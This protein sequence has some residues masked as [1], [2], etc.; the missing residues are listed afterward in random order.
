MTGSNAHDR[1]AMPDTMADFTDDAPV[2]D[3]RA[4]PD[5]PARENNPGAV[6]VHAAAPSLDGGRTEIAFVDTSVADY[7]T[8]AAD[9]RPGVEVVEIS[10]QDGLQQI[11]AYLAGRSDIAAV[12]IFSHGSAG[13]LAFGGEDVEADT[14]GTYQATLA[15][16]GQ[17]LAPGGDLLLYGCD[18]AAGS[19][20]QAL[21]SQIAAYSH[22]N[23]AA[24]TNP[25]GAASAGGDWD[26]EFHV[27]TID[28]A[29]AI[30]ATSG[31]NYRSVLS[32]YA[33]T[34]RSG[35]ST[36]SAGEPITTTYQ[37]LTIK[38]S[39]SGPGE[40]T[41]LV[42]TPDYG[43]IGTTY[44]ATTSQRLDF[45][46][47]N[48]SLFSVT[49]LYVDDP[50][51]SPTSVTIQGYNA[52]GTQTA[53]VTVQIPSQGGPILVNLSGMSGFA[54]IADLA[55]SAPDAVSVENLTLTTAPTV[56]AINRHAGSATPTNASSVIFDVTF[57]TAV[58]GVSAGNFTVTT[59]GVTVG[60]IG[61]VSGSGTA[62]TVTV[63]GVAGDGTLGLNLSSI[64]GITDTAG[65][66][67]G[68]T[69]TGDQSYT[70]DH[71]AP[72][73]GNLDGDSVLFVA[74]AAA[75]LVDN[76]S[77]ATVTEIN[78]ASGAILTAT[79]A[80]V[81]SSQD[82]LG[83]ATVSGGITTT[84]STTKTVLD[85][86]T[87][88]GTIAAATNGTGGQPLTVTLNTGDTI[89][90]VADLIRA[91]TYNDT[92]SAPTTTARSVQVTLTDAAGNISS[93]S[94]VA[95]QLDQ[96]PVVSAGHTTT[97]VRAQ[98]PAPFDTTLGI[99]DPDGNWTG[100]SVKFAVTT[101]FAANDMLSIPTTSQS[102]IW[103][104]G[105][106]LMD[107]ATQIGTGATSAVTGSATLT[108]TLNAAA[109]NVTVGALGQAVSIAIAAGAALTTRTVKIIATDSN[110]VAVTANDT[111][112]VHAQPTATGGTSHAVNDNA[113]TTPLTGISFSDGTTEGLTVRVS[114]AGATGSFG[115]PAGWSSSTTSGTTT[116]VQDFS[117]STPTSTAAAALAALIF[118]PIAHAGNVGSTQAIPFT[119]TATGDSIGAA[120]T[121]ISPSATVTYVNTTPSLAIGGTASTFFLG[122]SPVIMDSGATVTDPDNGGLGNW[123]GGQLN[124]TGLSV[125]DPVLPMLS[126]ANTGGISVSGTAISY[127]GINIGVSQSSQPSSAISVS[128]D[129]AATDAAVQALFRAITYSIN[130]PIFDGNH[131]VSVTARDGSAASFSTT[132]IVVVLNGTSV[133]SINRAA[134]MSSGPTDASTLSFTVTF[135]A[136]VTGVSVS[137]FTV[138][139][140]GSATGSL[141]GVS[142]SGTSWTVTVAGVAGDGTLGLN[143]SNTSGIQDAQGNPLLATYNS[144]QTF[145]LDHT[146][147][148]VNG[149]NGNAD[150]FV[151]GNSAIVLQPFLDTIVTE[152][153]PGG[154]TLTVQ[155]ANGLP[156][157][158][159]GLLTGGLAGGPIAVSNGT[160]TDDGTTIGT[161]AAGSNGV[162][163][164]L[165]VSL[166]S[167]DTAA[168]VSALVSILSYSDTSA[169][170]IVATRTIDLT[171]S[172]GAGNISAVS[173]ATVAIDHPPV[174]TA[175]HSTNTDR[176]A[177]LPIDPALQVSDADANWSGGRLVVQLSQNAVSTDTLSLPSISSSGIWLNGTALMAGS[178]Q[179]GTASAASVQGSTS[180]TFSLDANAT[181]AAVTALAQTVRFTAAATATLN[182][183][184]ITILAFDGDGASATG[185]DSV[186]VRTQPSITGG[187]ASAV[188]DNATITPLSGL[189]LGVA[190]GEGLTVSVAMP[191]APG[192][193]AN[194]LAAGWTVAT[195]GTT[196]TWTHDFTTTTAAVS[197]LAALSFAPA[198]HAEPP[199]TTQAVTFA[200]TTT[201]DATGV[202]ATDSNA[203]TRISY[204][205]TAPTPAR[206]S[207]PCR[208]F[209]VS[210]RKSSSARARPI[211]RCRRC[212]ARSSSAIRRRRL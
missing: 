10:G 142:G 79:I 132:E 24:S 121:D 51:T 195:S 197:A 54:N 31:A 48:H 108:F 199:G 98:A 74:G 59:T 162:A 131:E 159:L 45:T 167:G 77:N 157:D 201:A 47:T 146:A 177:A 176:T 198:A 72:V 150:T 124:A 158:V 152:A 175:G 203:S 35:T 179:I 36:S 143:L 127:D 187:T 210:P 125:M 8:L 116:Y 118:T 29:T 56:T 209:L 49:S 106:A 95:V 107:G 43:V 202:T 161:I 186:I 75:V 44:F 46:K 135:D 34:D 15:Q 16:I 148:V 115:N 196:T 136:A 40:G 58:T 87:A 3:P 41:E 155:V 94:T 151:V 180:W 172:D 140:T 204:I 84:G 52:S 91:L 89:T 119:V 178:T 207:P 100:G 194:G 60:T 137:N 1:H 206:R 82:V 128:L 154:G 70:L 149:F 191:S 20:G 9:V 67:L 32:T 183:R 133:S 185:T 37:D 63:T 62:W 4:R 168:Q 5:S 190:A 19:T 169:T 160:V 66:P 69:H 104:N 103:L 18:V 156:E 86:G 6:M 80:N 2:A 145:A 188:N 182:T 134:G 14:I 110:G 33:L 76:G 85:N 11:A 122:G 153:N 28:T 123:S 39:E 50:I 138:A 57:S 192:S 212:C 64:A 126:V 96:P 13:V 170:P 208:H 55:V 114:F 97:I 78:I 200:V 101:G 211:P 68:A 38:E 111:V 147:P 71:T 171:L 205:D 120:A 12:H 130:Y 174:I 173:T 81:Q 193:F 7:R 166:S 139:T 23:V 21:V 129:A 83:V 25:T 164:P 117:G 112:T 65:N 105:T 141:T 27:G 144:G 73:I 181:N 17:S 88:I 184:T 53:S 99:T 113:T 26:L 30:T 109:T 92:S 163:T 90:Q 22:A 93:A 102:G 61:T 189:T 42:F 165:I